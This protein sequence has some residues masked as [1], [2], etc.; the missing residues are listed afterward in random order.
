MIL[1]DSRD[2]TVVADRK[3]I[4]LGVEGYGFARARRFV[5]GWFPP[6][7][8]EAVVHLCHSTRAEALASLVTP[9]LFVAAA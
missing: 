3:A 9:P 6:E 2:P 7:G 1:I 5:D 4:S 8:R